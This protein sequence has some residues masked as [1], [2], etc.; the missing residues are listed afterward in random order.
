MPQELNTGFRMGQAEVRPLEGVIVL[1]G[2]TTRMEPKAMTVLVCLAESAPAVVTREQ[3]I[4]KVWPRGY[5]TDGAL[6]R[7]ISNLRAALGDSP[8]DPQFIITVPRKGYR[9][10]KHAEPLQGPDDQLGVLVLPLQNLFSSEAFIVD[11]LTEL[12]IARLAVALEQPV[13][14]RTTAMT[15]KNSARELASISEQLGVRW[16]LEG[17]VMQSDEQVQIVIQLI[18]ATTD[19]H[20]WADSWTRPTGDTLTVLNE[21]S[22]LVATR[23]RSELQEVA[24]APAMEQA[25]TTDLLRQ[26]LH[27]VYLN[28][29]RTH[30]SLRRAV[31]CFEQVLQAS[32]DHVPSLSGLAH[33]YVLLAHYG[34]VA[35]NEG[36]GRG[37]EYAK[38]ALA[39]E[40]GAPEALA[41]LAAVEFFFDWDIESA[42]GHVEQALE[43]HASNETGLL[44]AANI[45][46]VRQENERAQNYIDRALAVDPLNVGLLMNAGDHL[47]LQQRFGE[48][49]I[50]LDS[51]LQIEPDFR[52]ACLRLA[53]ACAFDAR[54]GD[55]KDC[56]QD[57][58]RMGGEDASYLE[59]L[60]IVSGALG[61]TKQATDAAQSLQDLAGNAAGVSPWAQAR[62]WAGAADQTKAI[63]FLQAAH[64]A[65]S[66]SMLFLGITPVFG[67]VRERPEVQELMAE[68][69]L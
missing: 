3:L 21:I 31:L 35:V 20:V 55:A 54:S 56:M 24:P 47:I 44:M 29:K 33:S 11:S 9:L 58:K 49:A 5:V 4:D 40:P 52:P 26:Y 57:A 28:S 14:S 19:T 8:R 7:C 37:R 42:R 46:L 50:A 68:L 60:A 38:T 2:A 30:Q 59:Y 17:S 45:A 12:L 41:N 65:R 64:A 10:A 62:A 67:S 51:A 6:N 66:S 39:L 18:D 23:V 61:N 13:I 25:L 53:L 63:Q 27:G 36:F 32:P 43:I 16:V 1:E 48:A 34:A 15:F 22:R 69:G